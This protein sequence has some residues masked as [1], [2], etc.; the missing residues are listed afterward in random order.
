MAGHGQVVAVSEWRW[1]IIA[2][3]PPRHGLVAGDVARSWWWAAWCNAWGAIGC[4]YGAEMTL[5]L[6]LERQ[7][8][9]TMLK[10]IAFSHQTADK[11]DQAVERYATERIPTK[12]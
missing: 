3:R 11:I 7:A 2:A 4:S 9:I 8:Y 1:P 6:A 10:R 12:G 5:A